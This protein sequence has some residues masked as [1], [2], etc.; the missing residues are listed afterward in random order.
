MGHKAIVLAAGSG[1][2]LAP[3]TNETPKALCRIAD[4]ALLDRAVDLIRPFVDEVAINACHHA[5]QIVAHVNG[6]HHVSVESPAAYGTGGA[7]AALREWLDGAD[8]FILNTDSLILGDIA[9]FVVGTSG[10]TV[11]LLV[12]YHRHRPDFRAMWRFSGLSFLPNRCIDDLPAAGLESDLYK[13]VWKPHEDRGVL[14]LQPLHGCAIDCGTLRDYLAANLTMN[15]GRSVVEAGAV[16][17]GTID[18]C[19]VQRDAIVEPGEHLVGAI[20]TA[21]GTTIQVL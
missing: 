3:L 7:V 13:R 21:A 19:I 4:V 14:Q 18:N 16:V 17:H 10:P 6:R 1:T 20:R 15:G 11:R 2:R 8:A 12:H 9:P 5:E